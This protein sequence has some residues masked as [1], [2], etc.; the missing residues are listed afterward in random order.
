MSNL[1]GRIPGGNIPEFIRIYGYNP[2][3]GDGSEKTPYVTGFLTDRMPGA[4]LD[5][6][7]HIDGEKAA[8]EQ[9]KLAGVYLMLSDGRIVGGPQVKEDDGFFEVDEPKQPEKRANIFKVGDKVIHIDAKDKWGAVGETGTIIELCPEYHKRGWPAVRIKYDDKNGLSLLIFED[10]L[11]LRGQWTGATRLGKCL[12][13]GKEW[14]AHFGEACLSP[15]QKWN[16]ETA[17]KNEAARAKQNAIIAPRTAYEVRQQK[18]REHIHMMEADRQRRQEMKH[19][20]MIARQTK[21][22]NRPYSIPEEVKK[23]FTVTPTW[24][25]GEN[26]RC[27]SGSRKYLLL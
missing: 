20:Q 7:K 5:W 3:S 22:I 27:P 17:E 2:C 8:I 11:K 4:K 23:A 1:H 13:C 18:E 6:Y 15:Q 25:S 21:F 10:N 9:A 12:E 19:E 26:N 16:K 24:E 14:G